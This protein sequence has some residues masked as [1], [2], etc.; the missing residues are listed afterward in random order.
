MQR[1]EKPVWYLIQARNNY[2][3]SEKTEVELDWREGERP[4]Q[5]L[6]GG[7]ARV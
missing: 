7:A 4:S 5:A 1:T 6:G 3:G 2:E